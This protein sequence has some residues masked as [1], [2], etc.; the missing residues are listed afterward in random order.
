[1]KKTLFFPICLAIALW[2]IVII[3]ARQIQQDEQT[4]TIEQE[5]KLD[6]ERFIAAGD[7]ITAQIILGTLRDVQKVKQDVVL[8]GINISK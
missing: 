1:M 7:T 3:Q 6:A 8:D 5:L 2:L 4:F